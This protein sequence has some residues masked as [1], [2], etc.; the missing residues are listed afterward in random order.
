[1]APEEVTALHGPEL[2]LSAEPCD[3]VGSSVTDVVKGEVLLGTYDELYT[4]C[5]SYLTLHILDLTY[6]YTKATEDNHDE[7][8]D[9]AMETNSGGTTMSG[10]R[11]KSYHTCAVSYG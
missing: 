2:I 6:E 8:G 1:M 5:I 7:A 4:E 10:K 3:Q 9:A 11:H